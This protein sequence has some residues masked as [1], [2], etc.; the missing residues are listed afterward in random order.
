MSQNSLDFSHQLVL[1]GG[2]VREAQD[3][4]QSLDVLVLVDE[5]GSSKKSNEFR[6]HSLR[7]LVLLAVRIPKDMSLVEMMRKY[8]IF[9]R[10]VDLAR[11]PYVVMRMSKGTICDPELI[12]DP[13]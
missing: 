6:T 13:M 2:K 5:R 8:C 12:R 7:D 1:V 3:L 4:Q 11:V 10:K 9:C